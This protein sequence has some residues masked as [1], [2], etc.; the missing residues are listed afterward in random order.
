MSRQD[1]RRSAAALI[2]LVAFGLTAGCGD[3]SPTAPPPP[4]DNTGGGGGGGGQPPAAPKVLVL[5][6]GGTE[7]HVGSA[8][9]TAGFD[10]TMGPLYSDYDGTDLGQHDAVILLTGIDYHN[11]FQPG[12]EQALVDF[13]AAGGGLLTTEWFLYYAGRSYDLLTPILPATYGGDYEY[14]GE[15]YSRVLDHPITL[16]LPAQFDVT[17]AWSAVQL[18]ADPAPEKKARV[19]F[20][21]SYSGDA[22]VA[23]QHGNGRVVS[24]GMAGEYD[25]T[26]IWTPD[27]DLLLSKIAGWL[28]G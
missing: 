9:S 22:V 3:D 5:A 12:V 15:T 24:W 6:D 13:V 21:G 4:E 25:G 2:G 10:V 27:V 20:H 16:G 19:L 26:D 8:L 23:G 28:A 7:V 14:Q 11:D 18:V 1:L 17:G